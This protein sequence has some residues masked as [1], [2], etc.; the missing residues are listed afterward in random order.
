MHV[1]RDRRRARPRTARRVA[2][3][4]RTIARI[5]SG[6]TSRPPK[7]SASVTTPSGIDIQALM[8]GCGV[9]LRPDRARSAPVR[10]SRRRCRTGWRPAPFG[11]SSGEQPITASAA[12][13]SRSITSSRMPG[14][15]SDPVAKPVG[16]R[17]RAAGLRCDQPQRAGLSGADLVAAD[18]ERGDGALDRGLADA[19]GRRDALAE[20]DDPREG[21]DHAKSVAGR[22]GDQ[23]PA[24]VGA[25]VERRVDAGSR[26]LR[27]AG[28]RSL[29]TAAAIGPA[30]SPRGARPSRSRV[31]SFI[32]N[33]FPRPVRADEEFPF[34]E[35][36]AA[37]EALA[38]QPFT[39]D[40]AQ[41]GV[42]VRAVRCVI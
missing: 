23:Q 20:P 17:G 13:V 5:D 7:C 29:A 12:S 15:G 31:S 26:R 42:V 33:V 11:S 16:V 37:R 40:H 39:W 35:T 38:Q 9:L 32:Q 8:R 4:P 24:I 22:T 3:P 14:L 28:R 2:R 25:E 18:A 27:A 21:I 10:S 30:A 1:A 19:A 36:L 41:S 6:V 34:T